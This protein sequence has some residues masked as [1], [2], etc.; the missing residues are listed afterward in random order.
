[1]ESI[2]YLG[3]FSNPTE[4]QKLSGA[5][6]SFHYEDAGKRI[7]ILACQNGE[8]WQQW[9]AENKYLSLNVDRVEAWFKYVNNL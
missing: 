7:T 9:G 8:V 6:V 2:I 4:S 5:D 1:M 3:C